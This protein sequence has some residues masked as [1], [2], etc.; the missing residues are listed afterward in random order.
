MATKHVKCHRLSSHSKTSKLRSPFAQQNSNKPPKLWSTSPPAPCHSP[1][2]NPPH[3]NTSP[4]LFYGF[5]FLASTVELWHCTLKSTLSHTYERTDQLI[6]QDHEP[7]RGT[8]IFA[9]LRFLSFSFSL[10]WS[11]LPLPCDVN[12]TLI[13]LPPRV[14]WCNLKAIWK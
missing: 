12:S 11:F 6:T 10:R 5:P 14:V 3:S 9:S 2:H 8:F 13:F 7:F 4:P 1:S